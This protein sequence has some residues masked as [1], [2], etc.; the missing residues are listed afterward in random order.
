MNTFIILYNLRR[1]EYFDSVMRDKKDSPK[2]CT[3]KVQEEGGPEN[4]FLELPI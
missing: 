1:L 3:G 4:E 2:Y